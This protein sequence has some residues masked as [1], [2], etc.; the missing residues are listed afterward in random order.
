MELLKLFVVGINL[1]VYLEVKI[2]SKDIH[3]IAHFVE[4]YWCQNARV[5]MLTN[6]GL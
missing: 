1:G 6:I 3:I 5:N 4:A 2:V